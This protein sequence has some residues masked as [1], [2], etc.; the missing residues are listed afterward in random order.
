MKITLPQ[1]VR[2]K[3]EA[4]GEAGLQWLAQLES[5]VAQLEAPCPKKLSTGRFAFWRSESRSR[6]RKNMFFS[7]VIQ[8]Q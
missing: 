4:T 3:A 2:G 6:T 7:P 1:M 5:L 8:N